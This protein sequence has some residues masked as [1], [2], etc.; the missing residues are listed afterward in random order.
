MTAKPHPAVMTIQPPPFPLDCLS[1]TFATTPSPRRTSSMVPI[2]SAE[3]TLIAYVFV[4][5]GPDA[6]NA[7]LERQRLNERGVGRIKKAAIAGGLSCGTNPKLILSP[8]FVGLHEIDA[9]GHVRHILQPLR[10]VFDGDV[11]LEAL[12]FKLVE[13]G[14][15]FADTR[16]VGRVGARAEGHLVLHVAADDAALEH[17]QAIDRVQPARLPVASVRAR[18]DAGVAVFR[19][20]DDIVRIPNLVVRLVRLARV[21][22]NAHSDVELLHEGLDDVELEDVL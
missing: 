10:L 13:A 5:D 9:L 14:R 12:L 21:I 4:W 18:A 2:N 22:V 1:R 3:K 7:S 6:S 19:H 8:A 11:A 17:A 16:A 15:N 20:G